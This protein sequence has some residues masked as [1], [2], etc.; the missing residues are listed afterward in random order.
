MILVLPEIVDY[1]VRRGLLHGALKGGQQTTRGIQRLDQLAESCE[2]VP[3]QT[4][5]MRKAAQLWAE[6]RIRGKP[7]APD[8]T[9]DA[10]PIL[11]AQALH[12]QGVVVTENVR[13]LEQFVATIRWLD[14]DSD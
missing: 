13:H 10:D 9:L 6:A 3:L 8:D 12:V 11:A 1:E 2:Y 4:T 5:M 7:T 14:I